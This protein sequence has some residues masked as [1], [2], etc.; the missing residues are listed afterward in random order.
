MGLMA[1]D[2]ALVRLTADPVEPS[3]ALGF[4]EDPSSGGEC[5]FVGTVRD[6]SSGGDVTGILYE[7]WPE[8]AESLLDKIASEMLDR[9][10]KVVLLH[11]FGEL[12]VGE[13]SVVVAASAVHREEA[14]AA[15]RHG[16][17]RIKEDVPIWKKELFA[18]GASGWVRGS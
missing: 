8:L 3:E 12:F 10:R 18:T 16:I 1:D 13:V 4:I 5:M 7:V 11:R 9:A 17:E 6:R 15:C 2:R 14:F